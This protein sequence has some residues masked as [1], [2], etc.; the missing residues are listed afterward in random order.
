M[1]TM[2]PA[3]PSSLRPR[4]T[5]PL[6]SLGSFLPAAFL[7]SCSHWFLLL[8][9]LLLLHLFIG[10]CPVFYPMC[11]FSCDVDVQFSPPRYWSLEHVWFSISSDFC[12][13]VIIYLV[14][15]LSMPVSSFWPILWHLEFRRCCGCFRCEFYPAE[16][17]QQ[18]ILKSSRKES[19]SSSS[20]SYGTMPC[21]L[22]SVSVR[23]WCGCPTFVPMFWR[24]SR[25][26][27]DVWFSIFSDF[28]QLVIIYPVY[29]ISSRSFPFMTLAYLMTSWISQ[30]LPIANSI[31][32]RVAD[33]TF[34]SPHFCSVVFAL[35]S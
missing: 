19:S 3:L 35:V 15:D 2:L 7:S 17:S 24:P 5:S 1:L 11:L 8:L 27:E 26:S 34:Q 22:S 12:Q 28:C 9:L 4:V 18:C 30:M 6:I 16:S 33:D 29:T 20:S 10:S 13:P 25:R 21:I 32:H 14:Y 31:P 23:L